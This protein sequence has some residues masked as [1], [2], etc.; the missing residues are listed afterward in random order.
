MNKI[1]SPHLKPNLFDL[2]SANRFD[3]IINIPSGR[4]KKSKEKTDGQ[5]IREAALKNKTYLITNIEVAKKFAE[6]I[7]KK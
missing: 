5:I 6:K 7:Q 1:S 3:V 4:I 2:L